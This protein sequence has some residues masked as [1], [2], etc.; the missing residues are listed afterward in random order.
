MISLRPSELGDVS[1]NLPLIQDEFILALLHLQTPIFKYGHIQRYWGLD[2][3]HVYL[4]DTSQ[5]TVEV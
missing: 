4:V 5:P 3:Q 2:F 1:P